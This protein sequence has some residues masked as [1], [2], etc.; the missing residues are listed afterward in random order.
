MLDDRLDDS[1]GLRALS[2]INLFDPGNELKETREDISNLFF[3][4]GR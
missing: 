1:L 4:L 3:Y 2:T